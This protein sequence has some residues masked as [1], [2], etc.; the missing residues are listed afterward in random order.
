M[1]HVPVLAAVGLSLLGALSSTVVGAQEQSG[2][3]AAAAAAT[4]GV[5]AGQVVP[6][7]VVVPPPPPTPE[8]I[9]AATAQEAA[10]AG[11]GVVDLKAGK[12]QAALPGMLV[13]VHY[14]GWLQ[15]TTQPEGKGHKF[16]S[17]RDRKQPFIIPLGQRRVIRGWDLGVVGMQVGGQRRLIIP[18]ALAYGERGAGNVIPPGATLIFDIELLALDSVR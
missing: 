2:S 7:G 1:K 3:N 9:L 11:L 14:T 15:D 5:P 8:Q 16:D 18:A 6:P 17:S 10:A 12:G 4:A 13:A